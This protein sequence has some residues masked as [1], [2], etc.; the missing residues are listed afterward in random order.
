MASYNNN[1]IDSMAVGL[2][3]S[4]VGSCHYLEPDFNTMDK[5]ILWD[6]EI[7]VYSDPSTHSKETFRERI[8][9]QIKGHEV[10]RFK[11]KLK[12]NYSIPVIDLQ[13]YKKDGGLLFFEIELKNNNNYRFYYK[14]L[15]PSNIDRYIKTANG[16]SSVSISFEFLDHL[17]QK[18]LESICDFFLEQHKKQLGK[19]IFDISNLNGSFTV[20]MD[21]LTSNRHI[22]FFK[23]A[24]VYIEIDGELAPTYLPIGSK[25]RTK[26]NQSIS[27]GSKEYFNCFTKEERENG[28]VI[29]KF[30]H[31]INILKTASSRKAKVC[32]Q[33][34]GDEVTIQQLIDEKDFIIALLENPVIQSKEKTVF[35]FNPKD[36]GFPVFSKKVK[37]IIDEISEYAYVLTYFGC[38]LNEKIIDLTEDEKG[39]ILQLKKVIDGKIKSS[40]VGFRSFYVAGK[41]AL[42]FVY[43]E[44]S[45]QKCISIFSKELLERF[46]FS[47]K[48]EGCGYVPSSPY[49]AIE[50]VEM[51]VTAINLNVEPIVESISTL[52]VHKE[53]ANEIVL[54]FLRF[55]SSYDKLKDENILKIAESFCANQSL[56]DNSL[57][58]LINRFQLIKRQ[59][60]LTKEECAEIID[61]KNK[62]ANDL[63]FVCCACLL[64]DNISEFEYNFNQ[65][66]DDAKQALKTYPIYSFYSP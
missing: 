30:G 65:L 64:L 45:T 42:V 16:Q 2:L 29:Y 47:V 27:I 10:D 18:Q 1:N 24:F 11:S 7:K 34:N 43:P 49:F 23:D 61:L 60:H 4:Y 33:F 55:L 12:T 28:D 40:E 51:L 44:S 14:V 50:D 38:S 41:R 8:P 46:A 3:M 22:D 56:C 36:T 37:Q 20:T 6:G 21:A 9:V 13:N 5:K 58:M 48:L 59:R 26:I 19:S 17:N 39:I 31:C 35:S 52:N 54:W 32:I 53:F 66:P 57:P 63:I 15:L 62:N 25:V